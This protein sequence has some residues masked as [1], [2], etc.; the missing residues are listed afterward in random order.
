MPPGFRPQGGT[1]AERQEAWLFEQCHDES[2]V[3]QDAAL[4]LLLCRWHIFSSAFTADLFCAPSTTIGSSTSRAPMAGARVR[5]KGL[6]ARPELN[7]REGVV[8]GRPT[9]S[10]SNTTSERWE[11][12]LEGGP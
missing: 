1:T 8:M 12:L 11:V 2:Y 6:T 3:L 4:N 9:S 7:G 5:L 10:S